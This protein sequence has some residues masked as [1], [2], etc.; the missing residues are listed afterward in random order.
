MTSK[1]VQGLQKA[2]LVDGAAAWGY[3]DPA[4]AMANHGGSHCFSVLPPE[5]FNIMAM[6]RYRSVIFLG[7]MAISCYFAFNA[8]AH[9]HASVAAAPV[10]SQQPKSWEGAC[11]RCGEGYTWLGSTRPAQRNCTRFVNGGTCN[12]A[13]IWQPVF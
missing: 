2:P 13:I 3:H 6:P 10:V 9:N 8:V 4:V 12:G 1:H 7:A 5:V 11:A